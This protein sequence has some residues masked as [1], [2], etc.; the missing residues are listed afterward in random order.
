MNW[1]F[2]F[3]GAYTSIKRLPPA[4]EYGEIPIFGRSNVGKSSF[5]NSVARIKHLAKTS[6]TPGKTRTINFY[7][8]NSLFYFVDLPG[9]GYA[10]ISSVKRKQWA[11]MV[12]NYLSH[13]PSIRFYIILIDIRHKLHDS[14]IKSLELTKHFDVESLVILTKKDKLNTSQFKKQLDYFDSS[15]RKY[16]IFELVPF[17]SVTGDGRE[18]IMLSIEK[19]L[20]LKNEQ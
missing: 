17:S 16:N 6:S 7:K 3:S 13:R 4:L 8:I 20:G 11:I 9:Y 19:R 18:K 5:I 2:D 14:D 12:M 1:K 15:L 10:K